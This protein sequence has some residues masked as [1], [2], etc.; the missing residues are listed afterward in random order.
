M[1]YEFKQIK[2]EEQIIKSKDFKIATLN[3][4]GNFDV[5]IALQLMFTKG[6]DILATQKPFHSSGG[7]GGPLIM[8]IIG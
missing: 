1:L 6:L 2:W 5:S 8:Y 7:Q 4:A 3:T